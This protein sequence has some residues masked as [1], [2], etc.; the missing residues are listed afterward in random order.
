MPHLL[1]G[2][3]MA[4]IAPNSIIKIMHN[5]PLDDTYN[6]TI[7]FASL[8]AQQT[9]FSGSGVVKYTL[10]K[11]SYQRVERGKMRV[12]ILSDNLYDCNY[13]AFQ[14]TSFGTKWFYAF[15]TSVEYIN[16]VTSEITFEIDVMQ[17]FLFDITVGSCFVEREHA[18]ND[19]AGSN[20]IAEPI[21]CPECEVVDGLNLIFTN[22]H[23][24]V[25]YAPSV[26]NQIAN[27]LVEWTDKVSTN[28]DGKIAQTTD[29]IAKGYLNLFKEMN[30]IVASTASALL[31]NNL[32]E[33]R[34]HQFTGM[35]P[36]VTPNY[37]D[38]TALG[39]ANTI[40]QQVQADI[41]KMN[42][43]GGKVL[44][45]Y[46]VPHEFLDPY[47][48]DPDHETSTTKY[49]AES[50]APDGPFYVPPSTFTPVPKF[51]YID[52][53]TYYTP[54]NNKL[55]TSPYTYIKIINKQ[56][57]ELNLAYEKIQ[58]KSFTFTSS[59]QNGHPTCFIENRKYGTYNTLMG[60]CK[61]L[62]RLQI[63]NFPICNFNSG[64]IISRLT[65]AVGMLS[66]ALM[67][68]INGSFTT[69]NPPIAPTQQRNAQ[70]QFQ[71]TGA[72]IEQYQKYQQKMEDYET[73]NAKENFGA[74][75]N[76][77]NSIGALSNNFIGGITNN[78]GDANTAVNDIA[79][80]NF[81]FR[82]CIMQITAE[83][84]EIIDNFFERFGYATKKNKVPNM[85]SRPHW[86]YVKCTDAYITGNCP[87]EYLS[88]IISIFNHG[89][90]FWKVPSEVGNY[91]LNNH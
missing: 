16:D 66:K 17:S 10:D 12:E 5:V 4:Y 42:A 90:T 25:N 59:W 18:V 91:T 3:D 48:L 52:K 27:A 2:K 55:Y 28:I 68:N 36:Y 82:I 79:N 15:I 35:I 22:W 76:Y 87:Q 47:S 6:H 14:N 71:N 75:E 46:Q 44:E 41:D 74:I 32:G 38:D 1:R 88:K 21:D 56:G 24:A 30:S 64:G 70:G 89:I 77:I 34:E 81:G 60:E 62:C 11:Q 20:T 58:E 49:W 7:K 8:S 73:R 54:K 19:T 45:V 83:Y 80:D 78:R 31:P 13:L 57:G 43:L 51:S 23:I 86:N 39:N 84:A 65:N 63:S 50:T 40:C 53:A 33:I 29:T 69:N 85:D 67:S 26:I 37:F 9:Y 61:D 72:Y